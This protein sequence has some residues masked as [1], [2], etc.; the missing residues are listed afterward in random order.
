MPS[1]NLRAR[2]SPRPSRLLGRLFS[3][4]VIAFEA[5]EPIGP[6]TLLEEEARCVERAVPKRVAEF[7][8]GR[9]CARRALER[10]AITNFALRMGANREPLWP[11]AVTGSIT[12]T[13]GFCGVVVART[14]DAASLG[15]D[16]ERRDAVRRRLWR[17]IATAAELQWLEA[18]PPARA[19][20]MASLVFSAKEAFFKCQFPLTREWLSFADVSV[21]I[22]PRATRS[23]PRAVR[24]APERVVALQ[25]SMAPPWTGR[26]ALRDGLIVTGF[27]LPPQSVLPPQAALPPR[28]L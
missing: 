17:H 4:R 26:Y 18:L 7:A 21:S 11:E 9:A 16:A 10:L 12:H 1:E 23:A 13:A 14:I 22:E 15:I 28:E 8:A 20:D 25:A 5:R 24:I 27:A 3:C 19:A 6:Q 2:G